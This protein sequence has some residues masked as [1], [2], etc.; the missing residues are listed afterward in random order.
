MVSYPSMDNNQDPQQA[1]NREINV[2]WTA[3]V[4]RPARLGLIDAVQE[5]FYPWGLND[6]NALIWTVHNLHNILSLRYG[7]PDERLDGYT[8][9]ALNG[10][11]IPGP[12]RNADPADN[13]GSTR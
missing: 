1:V 9:D 4:N 6:G 2:R 8:D 11:V 5:H 13:G 10:A 3:E 12:V 7:R